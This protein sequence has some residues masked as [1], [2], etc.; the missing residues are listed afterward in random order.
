MTCQNWCDH[1]GECGCQEHGG[2]DESPV[3]GI[4][5]GCV[6]EFEIRKN[7][8]EKGVDNFYRIRYNEF[9]GK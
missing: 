1:A 8:N 5:A 4:R 2:A 6:P 9:G 3:F 7:K